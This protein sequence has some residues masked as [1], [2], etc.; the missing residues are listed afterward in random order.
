MEV[1]GIIQFFRLAGQSLP[2]QKNFDRPPQLGHGGANIF[3]DLGW[4]L[5]Q[6]MGQTVEKRRQG[7]SPG[8]VAAGSLPKGDGGWFQ[9][10][11]EITESLV[12]IEA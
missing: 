6:T 10:R 9:L 5:G 3:N 8:N 1:A 12:K 2:S 11:G 4:I 7:L